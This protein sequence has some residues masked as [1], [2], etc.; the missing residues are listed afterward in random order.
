MKILFREKDLA[1]GKY[2]PVGKCTVR[3]I[4]VK[5][6]PAKTTGNDVLVLELRGVGPGVE[7][8]EG[9]EYL[10]LEPKALWKLGSL[11]EACGIPREY[12]TNGDFDTEDLLGKIFDLEKQELG[13]RVVNGQEKKTYKTIYHKPSISDDQLGGGLDAGMDDLPF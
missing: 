4:S 8:K 7:G 12:L 1:G 6:Q 3:I 5:N 11:A 10:S 2:L 13:S 9:M